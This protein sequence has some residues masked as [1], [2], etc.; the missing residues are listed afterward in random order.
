MNT[1]GIQ[2]KNDCLI[3]IKRIAWNLQYRVRKERGKI[4]ILHEELIG[5][6]YINELIE[7]LAVKEIIE[8]IP[9]SQGQYIMKSIYVDKKTE[10]EIAF[11]LGITQQ[12]VNKCKNKSLRVLREQLAIYQI[13]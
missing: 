5:T 6:E 3:L 13:I 4:G 7:D 11:E 1:V 8:K 2:N 10:K 9:S 12:S